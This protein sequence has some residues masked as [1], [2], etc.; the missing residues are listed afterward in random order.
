[1]KLKQMFEFAIKEAI[2]VD[3][4][5]KK[6]INKQLEKIKKE[7]EKL[8]KKKKELFDKEKLWN[9]YDDS[10]ILF[11]TGNENVKNIMVGIDIGVAEIL[12]ADKLKEK[13]DLVLAHHPSGKALAALYAVM[14]L[15]EDLFAKF[16]VP[17][18]QAE[19]IMQ[20]RIEEVKRKF[21]AI[22]HTRAQDAAKLLN[23]PLANF[24]TPSDNHVN[25]FLQKY[26]ERKDPYNLEELIDV[27]LDLPEYR[28]AAKLNSGPIIFNGKPSSRCGKILVSMTGGTEP[29]KEIYAKLAQAGVSTTVEMHVNEENLKYAKEHNINIVVAGHI[30]SDN[31]GM[32]IL[33]DKIERKF[34]K[35]KVVPVSGF[36]RFEHKKEIKKLGV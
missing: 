34:H 21:H 24:H 7:Y 33:L 2:K 4:R 17:I 11:G 3:P 25:A 31:L 29:A 14:F 16:G 30:C 26:L 27:L 13:V 35:L 36:R 22:N 32:N 15:Q 18:S 5:G 10:R 12:L 20:T 1:M 23:I 28:E 6:V 19:A 8:P 9:P